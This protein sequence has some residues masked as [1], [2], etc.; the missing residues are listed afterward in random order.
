MG[1]PFVRGV[2]PGVP[3]DA[4]VSGHRFDDYEIGPSGRTRRLRGLAGYIL[5]FAILGGLFAYLFY[6]LTFSWKISIGSVTLLIG[7]MLLSGW[8]AERN[9]SGPDNTMR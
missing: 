3:Y 4:E 5:L 6:Q 8:W 9:A 7:Y 2:C 1:G